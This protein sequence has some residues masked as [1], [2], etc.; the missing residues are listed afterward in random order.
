ME[1]IYRTRGRGAPAVRVSQRRSGGGR[2]GPGPGATP[3]P[4]WGKAINASS[5]DACRLAW[6][7]LNE[8]NARTVG[9]CVMAGSSPEHHNPGVSDCGSSRPSAFNL[10]ASYALVRALSN[11]P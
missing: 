9:S 4:L 1:Q 8:A 7:L 5:Q 2:G 6:N 11:R 10:R 3:K